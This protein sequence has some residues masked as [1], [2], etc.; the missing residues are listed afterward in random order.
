M[1]QIH[2]TQTNGLHHQKALPSWGWRLEFVWWYECSVSFYGHILGTK[3]GKISEIKTKTRLFFHICPYIYPKKGNTPPK[4]PP[5]RPQKGALIRFGFPLAVFYPT[6]GGYSIH[7]LTAPLIGGPRRGI[8]PW[9]YNE[10]SRR[11]RNLRQRV[12]FFEELFGS[13]DWKV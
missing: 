13:L 4:N 1:S 5:K 12:K 9:L 6:S 2:S 3:V 11:G 10:D 7:P 8:P